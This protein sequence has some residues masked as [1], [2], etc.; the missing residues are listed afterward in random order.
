MNDVD[1]IQTRVRAFIDGLDRSVIGRFAVDEH[2]LYLALVSELRRKKVEKMETDGWAEY[3]SSLKSAKRQFEESKRELRDVV[4]TEQFSTL[5][6]TELIFWGQ[7]SD[8]AD[9]KEILL[10]GVSWSAEHDELLTEVSA[11]PV[12]MHPFFEAGIWDVPFIET[13]IADGVDVA[14]SASIKESA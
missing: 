9:L 8:E 5:V 1:E 7:R 4:T 13:C 10:W 6:Y 14:I 3:S 12:E 11:H 2:A